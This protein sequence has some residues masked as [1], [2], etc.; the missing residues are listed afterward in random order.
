MTSFHS[1][2]AQQAVLAWIFLIVGALAI[3]F[4]LFFLL[5]I[6]YVFFKGMAVVFLITGIAQIGYGCYLLNISP[7]DYAPEASIFTWTSLGVMLCGGLLHWGQAFWKGA[8]LGMII[9]GCL[10][11]GLLMIHAGELKRQKETITQQSVQHTKWGKK[12]SEGRN[13]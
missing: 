10:S 2:A 4:A 11:F 3:C 12:I 9:Q 8:G 6:K 13:S 5:I 1:L 7:N